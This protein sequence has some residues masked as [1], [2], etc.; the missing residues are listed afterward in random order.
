MVLIMLLMASCSLINY[1][2]EDNTL[3][4]SSINTD[5]TGNIVKPTETIDSMTIPTETTWTR[6]KIDEVFE[7]GKIS[8]NFNFTFGDYIDKIN[9][10][11]GLPDIVQDE[12]FGIRY[13]NMVIF[14]T[15][16]YGSTE[17]DK[18]I[19]VMFDGESEWFG[20]KVRVSNINDVKELL[21][22]PIDEYFMK[23]WESDFE[24]EEGEVMPPPDK[25]YRA[26]PYDLGEYSSQFYFTDGILS[27]IYIYN[28]NR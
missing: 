28:P 24:P 18:V 20:L 5:S 9:S 6:E 7:K 10:E 21:G 4:S 23:F 2:E 13:G 1:D 22:E 3:D 11:I 8:D 16:Y 17:P 12:Y 19:G 15:N 26:Y 25:R 14:T 27:N